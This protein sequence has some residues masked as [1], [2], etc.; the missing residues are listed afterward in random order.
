MCVFLTSLG[1]IWLASFSLSHAH[2]LRSFL[3]LEVCQVRGFWL[4][5]S[6]LRVCVCRISQ[7]VAFS[8]QYVLHMLLRRVS[9]HMFACPRHVRHVRRRGLASML[10]EQIRMTHV[11]QST[12]LVEARPSTSHPSS[13]MISPASCGPASVLFASLGEARVF[14]DAICNV[15]PACPHARVWVMLWTTPSSRVRSSACEVLLSQRTHAC[16]AV[17]SAR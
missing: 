17:T 14:T 1:L 11:L 5:R 8:V 3:E 10:K 2:G 4:A 7:L 13:S 15:A 12:C 9:P 6:F 16:A